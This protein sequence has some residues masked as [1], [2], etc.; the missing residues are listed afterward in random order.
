MFY[1]FVDMSSENVDFPHV[2]VRSRSSSEGTMSNASTNGTQSRSTAAAAAAA[3][4]AGK[5]AVVAAA[6]ARQSM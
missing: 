4:A 6:A 2:D 3:A 5:Q 1:G